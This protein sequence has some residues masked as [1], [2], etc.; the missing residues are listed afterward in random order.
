MGRVVFWFFFILTLEAHP[1]GDYTPCGGRAAGMGFSSVAIADPWS[2]FNNQA[3]LTWVNKINAEIYFENRFLVKE[4]ALKAIGIALPIKSGTFGLSFREFGFSLY[5]EM[6]TGLAFGKKLGKSFSAG[7]QLDYLR[8]HLGE[9]LGT[10]HLFTFEIGME[11]QI[12]HNLCLG[13]HFYNPI[14]V[15][16]T[17]YANER[18]PSVINLGFSWKF[19]EGFITTIEVEKDIQL[20]PIFKAGLEYHFVKPVYIRIGL[21]TNPAMFTFGL[22]FEF[23]QVK[24]DF[25]SSYHLVLGYS[26]QVSLIYAFL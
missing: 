11:F 22:G 14:S 20:K 13:V 5:N 12:N 25:A 1:A 2:V 19:S 7:V 4:M 16:L 3:G 18:I 26:P 17:S 8:I 10:K 15:K 9:D 21:L 6:T 24:F 23:G